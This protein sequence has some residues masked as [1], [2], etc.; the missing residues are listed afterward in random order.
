MTPAQIIALIVLLKRRRKK[1]TRTLRGTLSRPLAVALNSQ[2]IHN[3]YLCHHFLRMKPSTL[4]W[5]F[6]RVSPFLN[7]T[8]VTKFEALVIFLHFLGAND[9]IATQCFFF[10][11]SNT[12]IVNSRKIAAQ[13][14]LDAFKSDFDPNGRLWRRSLNYKP[15]YPELDGVFGAIDGTHVLIRVR[16]VWTDVFRNR[17]N[18]ISTNVMILCNFQYI[19]FNCRQEILYVGSGYPGSYHDSPIFSFSPLKNILD[20]MP[21]GKF[22]LADAGYALGKRVL[23]PFRR[24]RYHL[25]E[26]SHDNG[27]QNDKELYNLRHSKL[28]NVIERVN[29]VLKRRW[30]LLRYGN[31][32]L[33]FRFI[34][35]CIVCCCLL[36]NVLTRKNDLDDLDDF[37]EDE[38]Q[39]VISEDADEY[40]GTQE[41]K[42]ETFK[43]CNQWRNTIA[44][45][46][47][48][49]YKL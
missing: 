47:W 15:K 26:W 21:N 22:V 37:I 43:F 49:N 36:H 39:K 34:S 13:A 33:N 17:H 23:T 20:K 41:K 6:N 31:E 16:S 42:N 18:D 1:R 12:V 27:P 2:L 5:I 44:A 8:Y 32:S 45:T 30:R 14:V 35:D 48:S 19:Y 9:T 11:L 3:S 28:R 24:T 46:M 38:N 4:D 10:G 25:K 7:N 29:G 40:I